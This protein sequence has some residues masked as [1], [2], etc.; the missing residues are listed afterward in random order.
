M[1]VFN[2]IFP[3]LPGKEDA[4]RVFAK[5]VSG[6]RKREFGDMQTRHGLTRETWALQQ[7]PQ[8]SFVLVW[9][10][11]SDVEK[12]FAALA[13]EQDDFVV[14]F[15]QQVLDVTGVDMTAPPE[16]PMPETL[17]EWSV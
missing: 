2:G 8:G 6:P 1:A 5:E 7:T 14:W 10:E 9:F 13:T 4:A 15:R 17:V 11:A 16:D 3:V 12:P